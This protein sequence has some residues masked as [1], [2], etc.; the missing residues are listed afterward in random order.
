M[1]RIGRI[2]PRTSITRRQMLSRS[3]KKVFQ[4]RSRIVDQAVLAY[5]KEADCESQFTMAAQAYS[6]AA[7]LKRKVNTSEA[8]KLKEKAI[9]QLERGGNFTAVYQTMLQS[10]RLIVTRRLQSGTQMTMS[11]SWRS[12]ITAAPLTSLPMAQTKTNI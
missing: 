8:V 12:N 2:A 6:S 1:K 9:E 7:N 10:R 3:P 5:E 4:L 11:S